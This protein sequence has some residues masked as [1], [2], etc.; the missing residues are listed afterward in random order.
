MSEINRIMNSCI[1]EGTIRHRRFFPRENIFQYRIFLM[2]LD[3]A[4]LDTVFDD[5]PLWSVGRVNI[6]YLRRKDHFG[7]P[8]VPIDHAVRNLVTHKTGLSPRG[9]IRMLTHLR[10]WGHCFNPVTFYFCYDVQDQHVE[11][12]VAEIHNTPWGEHYC[13][14]LGQPANEHPQPQWRRYKVDKNFHV[15]PFIDMDIHYD[16]RFR[17][18][19]E[20][21]N[22]HLIDYQK[23]RKLFDATLILKRRAINRHSL[24]HMLAKY[25]ILTV[26]VISMIYW[27]AL[28]LVLKKTP[29]YEHPGKRENPEKRH[30]Q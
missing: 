1:Y 7:D 26:K 25:P 24:T 11:T 18:P 12:I 14:V 10:Y 21:L 5:H 2:F 17:E 8:S 15:S 9:P 20:T 19:G 16:W 27:Q 28:R 22:I 6:A 23:D 29:F 30:A 13:Y 3:L 4:E